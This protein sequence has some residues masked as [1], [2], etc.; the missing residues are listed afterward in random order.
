VCNSALHVGTVSRSKGCFC[1][2]VC[3]KGGG[4]KIALNSASTLFVSHLITLNHLIGFHKT[5]YESH[6]MD[7]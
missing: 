4:L 2:Y 3:V 5:Q 7:G 1:M 6:S